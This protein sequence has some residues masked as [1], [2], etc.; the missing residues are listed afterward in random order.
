MPR[1]KDWQAFSKH[2]AIVAPARLAATAGWIWPNGSTPYAG[3]GAG[4]TRRALPFGAVGTCVVG[5][6]DWVVPDLA[7]GV[8]PLVHRQPLGAVGEDVL[9]GTLP[10]SHVRWESSATRKIKTEGFGSGNGLRWEE[11]CR[12]ADWLVQTWDWKTQRLKSESVFIHT[13]G[14][15][16][17]NFQ[18]KNNNNLIID[19]IP[20][21]ALLIC[22]ACSI[23][24]I[25]L[26]F[27]LWFGP[28]SDLSKELSRFLGPGARAGVRGIISQK[29]GWFFFGGHGKG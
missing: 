22:H 6:V 17:R 1:L 26:A 27:W 14:E 9:G 29:F 20:T 7:V 3:Q 19:N 21:G 16:L 10:P 18:K 28:F 13:L 11:F 25:G 8:K 23:I 4:S 5:W 12:L 24:Q 15:I 2:T